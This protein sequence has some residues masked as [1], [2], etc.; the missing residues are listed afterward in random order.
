MLFFCSVHMVSLQYCWNGSVAQ[1]QQAEIAPVRENLLIYTGHKV[2][3]LTRVQIL[4]E[5]WKPALAFD[6][7]YSWYHLGRCQSRQGK[8]AFTLS[9]WQMEWCILWAEQDLPWHQSGESVASLGVSPDLLG[10]RRVSALAVGLQTQHCALAGLRSRLG[11]CAYWML[12]LLPNAIS[13]M[14]RS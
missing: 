13:V 8:L 9:V 1:Q 6:L 5:E 10:S 3:L 12:L 4:T 14:N 7:S 11:S 2:C